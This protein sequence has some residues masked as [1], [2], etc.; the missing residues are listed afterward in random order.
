MQ[1]RDTKKRKKH[2][3]KEKEPDSVFH[4]YVNMGTNHGYK[5][6]QRIRLCKQEYLGVNDV[7]TRKSYA[8]FA[9]GPDG[10]GPSAPRLRGPRTLGF[11]DFLCEFIIKS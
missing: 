4:F 7:H 1:G 8:G 5:C 9:C 2:V 3:N 11:L 10:P 6:Y